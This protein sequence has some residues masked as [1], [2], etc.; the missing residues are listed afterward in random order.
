M[1]PTQQQAK[2]NKVRSI[3]SGKQPKARVAR[4]LKKV[5]PQ[6]VE[7]PKGLLLLKGIRC[8]E[9]MANL[10]KDLRALNAPNSKMLNKTN[11]ILPFEDTSSLEFLMTKND[12]SL[13][14]LGSHNKKRPNNLILGRTF[15]HQILDLLEFSISDYRGLT[16]L[17]SAPKKRV[18]SK[19]LMLFLGDAWNLDANLGRIQNFFVDFFRGVPV[20]KLAL[21]GMDH[22]ITFATP[23][24]GKVIHMRTYYMKL[25]KNPSGGTVPI[26]YLTQ[27]GPDM[28][29]KV[30]K[31]QFLLKIYTQMFS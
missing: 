3:S 30:I 12:S 19:P 21:S 28:D 8:S 9:N 23:P 1:A 18:G 31:P 16:D 4:Y 14:A 22:I 26:P 27:S 25:K 13:F 15:D 20:T 2:Q 11:P 6:L 29:M 10:L 17:K 7:G 5:G 24:D